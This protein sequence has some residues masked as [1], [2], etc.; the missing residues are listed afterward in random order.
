MR[1]VVLDVET[2]NPA[3]SSICQ[4]GMA[5][6]CDGE[7]VKTWSSLV[8]PDDYFDDINVSIHRI[9]AAT[10]LGAP[11][12]PSVFREIEGLVGAEVVVSH[13]RFDRTA[14]SQAC[15]RYSIGSPVFRWLDSA[16]VVRRAWPVFSRSGYGLANVASHLGIQFKHHDAAEDARAAGEILMRAISE[17]GL[18]VDQWLERVERP[19]TIDDLT[20][21][22][23]PDGVLLGQTVV[24]TGALSMPRRQAADLA[25]LAG[26]TVDSGVTRATTVLVV[27]DQDILK[28]AGHE[29]SSKH[30]KAEKLIRDGQPIRIIGESDFMRLIELR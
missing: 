3:F 19:I 6:F 9:D 12:W 18:N 26:C 29:K 4:V 1:Y 27:G 15:D 20:R 30:R 10:V 22:P 11:M 8:D 5:F 7:L 23:N 24:F 21:E 2:A 16:R 13:S 25:A 14:I 17:T 28:L